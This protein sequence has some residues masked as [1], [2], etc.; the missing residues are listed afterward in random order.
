MDMKGTNLMRQRYSSLVPLFRTGIINI[1]LRVVTLGSKFLLLI[2]MAQRLSLDELGVYGIMTVTVSFA[3]YFVGMDFYTFN[4]RDMLLHPKV[5]WGKLIRDQFA[6][7]FVIYTV[8][9]PVLSLVFFIGVIGWRYAIWFYLLL[10]LEHLGQETYRVI[11]ASG[12]PTTA[13]IYL[14]VRS[15]FWPYLAVI[16]MIVSDKFAH[17]SVVFA[18]WAAASGLSLLLAAYWLRGLGWREGWRKPVDWWRIRKGVGVSLILLMATLFLR[19]TTLIDRYMLER[20]WALELVGVYTFFF[21]IAFVLQDFVNVGVVTSIYP[22][23]ISTYQRGDLPGHSQLFGALAKRV[24]LVTLLLG[25]TLALITPLILPFLGKQEFAQHLSVFMVLLLAASLS[26]LSL[27]PFY[28]LYARNADRA[29]LLSSLLSLITCFFVDFALIPIYGPI[30]AAIGYA[31]AMTVLLFSRFFFLRV[32]SGG[33]QNSEF[34]K[35]LLVGRD[36]SSS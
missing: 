9:L 12:R 2:V 13:L 29:I 27:I 3:I 17:V 35:P 36:R 28:G 19:G 30:G 14:F 10:I 33:F 23:L 22:R 20:Y 11:E 18:L 4:I 32:S 8:F 1:L 5:E 16:L 26:V 25:G 24:F 31:A 15:G 7:H 21:S 6:L 34:L